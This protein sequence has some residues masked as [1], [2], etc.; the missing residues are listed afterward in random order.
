MITHQCNKIMVSEGATPNR[1]LVDASDLHIAPGEW[2]DML[3]TDLGNGQPLERW[4]PMLES[5]IYRQR[6]GIIE[7]RVFND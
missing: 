4:K 5:F 3:S 1:F 2:P 6:F 7:V